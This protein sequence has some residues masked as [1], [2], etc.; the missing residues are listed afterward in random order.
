MSERTIKAGGVAGLL[1][2]VLCLAS[3]GLAQVVGNA[4]VYAAP[5]NIAGGR[6]L[7]PVRIGASGFLLVGSVILGVLVS[8]ARSARVC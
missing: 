6:T 8:G 7:V 1:A 5:S 3:T 4:D 2:A